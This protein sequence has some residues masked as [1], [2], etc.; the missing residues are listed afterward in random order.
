MHSMFQH[1]FMAGCEYSY[2][3]AICRHFSVLQKVIDVAHIVKIPVLVLLLTPIWK[4]SGLR[5]IC[6]QSIAAS[7]LEACFV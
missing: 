5:T 4:P 7:V 6:E 2:R 3:I 1:S